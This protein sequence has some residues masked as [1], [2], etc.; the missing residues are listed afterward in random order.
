MCGS[1]TLLCEALMH[2]ARIPAGY[3]R[4]TFGF[5]RLPDFDATIWQTEKAAADNAIRSLADGLITGSDI[6][7][8]A[9]SATRR[10]L[11][12]LPGGDAVRTRQADFRKLEIKNATIICNPP[13]GMRLGRGGD[14][15]GFYKSLG[16]FLKQRC[17][18]SIAYIYFGKREWIK[19][20]GLRASWKK[21]LVSGA[22]DGRLVKVEVY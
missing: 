1:G 18:N 9:V 13:Y 16:D 22:L 7:P 12:A 10:N 2:H 11:S 19:S 20:L 17:T 21:P 6:D 15:A 5:E 8:E 4:T 3:L 14:M